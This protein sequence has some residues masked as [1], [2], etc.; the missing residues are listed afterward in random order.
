M[1]D[2]CVIDG[3]VGKSAKS[4]VFTRPESYDAKFKSLLLLI[5]TRAWFSD[6][7]SAYECPNPGLFQ[8]ISHHRLQKQQK[9]ENAT[10]F[11][12]MVQFRERL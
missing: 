3:G 5:F 4:R 7:E 8:D 1:I 11:R 12:R 2:A 9:Q 6:T 10:D